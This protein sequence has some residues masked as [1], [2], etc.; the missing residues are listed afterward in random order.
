[1][2]YRYADAVAAYNRNQR[3]PANWDSGGHYTGPA[4]ELP[5]RKEDCSCRCSETDDL[6][7]PVFVGLCGPDCE[8]RQR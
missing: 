2:T 3:D 8:R 6:G 7:R 5:P 1:M 4:M